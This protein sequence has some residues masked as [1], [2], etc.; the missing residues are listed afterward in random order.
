[1]RFNHIHVELTQLSLLFASKLGSQVLIKD[2]SKSI[3]K[4]DRYS[5]IWQ[6]VIEGHH[7]GNW[8]INLNPDSKLYG[9]FENEIEQEPRGVKPLTSAELEDAVQKLANDLVNG[10]VVFEAKREEKRF[11]DRIRE[12]KESKP[13]PELEP[14]LTF[15]A[16]VLWVP[17][18]DWSDIADV[19]ESV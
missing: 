11:S 7:Q 6:R 3:I 19:V 4:S 18:H 16:R 2:C 12:A 10:V 5:E 1:M 14:L 15:L 17:D 8:S 9:F 13:S